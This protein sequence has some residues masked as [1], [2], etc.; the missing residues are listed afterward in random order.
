MTLSSIL[1]STVTS[2]VKANHKVETVNNGTGA[3]STTTV[4]VNAPASNIIKDAK[5]EFVL[6]ETGKSNS[7]SVWKSENTVVTDNGSRSSSSSALNASAGTSAK[8]SVEDGNLN[9]TAGANAS[10]SAFNANGSVQHGSFNAKGEVTALKAEATAEVGFKAGKDGVEASAKVGASATVAEASGSAS[11]GNGNLGLELGAEGRVL[12]ASA[13]AEAKIGYAKN[14]KTGEY[15]LNAFLSAEANAVL[16][17][18]NVHGQVSLGGVDVTAKAGVYVGVGGKVEI[19]IKDGEF[20]FDISA[21]LGIGFNLKFT[22]GFNDEFLK[23]ITYLYNAPGR[24]YAANNPHIKADTTKLREFATRLESV[25]KR[26]STLG[27]NL[28][29]VFWEVK[30]KDMWKFIS[31]NAV[32]G[33][34]PTLNK[35]ISYLNEAAD[36][37]EAAEN[38]ARENMGG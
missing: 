1:E 9:A 11:I 21:A 27:G 36:F 33:G 6:A 3:V 19:G 31:I 16:A 22:I 20:V 8:I 34:S 30:A 17:E 37:L 14:E 24:N 23:N 32:T 18:G 5:V 26:L 4:T 38:K 13:E 10:V 25:N 15:E 12:S 29:N 7:V 28:G 2:G 35:V